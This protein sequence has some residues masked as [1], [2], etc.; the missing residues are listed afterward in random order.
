MSSREIF[1]MPPTP[2]QLENRIGQIKQPHHD[3]WQPHITIINRQLWQPET[4]Q[5]TN[6]TNISRQPQPKQRIKLQNYKQRDI[7]DA[8]TAMIEKGEQIPALDLKITINIIFFENLI[9]VS[10][11]NKRWFLEF[12]QLWC[13]ANR[14]V[15]RDLQM[16]ERPRL[17]PRQS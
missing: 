4:K 16:W 8:N 13:G 1:R 6:Q 3:N 11:K 5:P 15:C 2:S 17:R 14:T 12:F 7:W 10:L 9:I